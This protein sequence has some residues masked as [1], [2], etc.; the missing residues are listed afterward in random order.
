MDICIY[1]NE[2]LVK[3]FFKF[4][5]GYFGAYDWAHEKFPKAKE[6]QVDFGFKEVRVLY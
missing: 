6:I 4:F 2:K 1:K 3:H 5:P